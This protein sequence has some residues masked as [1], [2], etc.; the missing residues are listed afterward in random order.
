MN[1]NDLKFGTSGLRRAVVLD[2]LP[3]FIHGLGVSARALYS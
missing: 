1:P 3:A 2:G